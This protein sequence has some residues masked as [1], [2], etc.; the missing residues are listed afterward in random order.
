MDFQLTYFEQNA[1]EAPVVVT[2][3]LGIAEMFMEPKVVCAEGHDH[4]FLRAFVLDV[5]LWNGTTSR[6]LV[7]TEGALGQSLLNGDLE[8]MAKKSLDELEPT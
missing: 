6:L 5:E 3:N 7:P 4:S 2:F 8:L 1:T